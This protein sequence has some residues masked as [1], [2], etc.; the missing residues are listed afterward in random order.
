M[1]PPVEYHSTAFQWQLL[2]DGTRD[3]IIAWLCW[4]DPN[5]TYTDH[6]SAAEGCSALTRE[7]AAEIMRSQINR[8]KEPSV[9]PSMADAAANQANIAEIDRLVKTDKYIH[10]VAWGKFLGFT[11]ATVLKYV[12]E[13]ETDGAPADAIQKIE[14]RW[15]TLDDITNDSNRKRVEEIARR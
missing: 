9:I 14:G 4:N 3:Q 5:G 13:A 6:D 1:K 8:D 12:Q 11:P 15:L 7:R 10:V 2:R